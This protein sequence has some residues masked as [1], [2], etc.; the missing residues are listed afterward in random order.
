MEKKTKIDKQN[1]KNGPILHLK[2]VIKLSKILW[3]RFQMAA[4]LC[5]IDQNL[6]Q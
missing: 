6:L 2:R 1:R 4:F 5:G 3:H